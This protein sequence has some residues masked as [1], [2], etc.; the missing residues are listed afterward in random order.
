MKSNEVSQGFILIGY[1][2]FFISRFRKNKKSILI[3]DNISRSCFIV[4][5]YLFGSINSIEH[6]IYGMIRNVVGQLLISRKNIYKIA[7]F[8]VM[9]V[10][11]F[12]MYGMSFSGISTILFLLSGTINLCTAIFAREQGIRLGTVFAAVCNVTAFLIIGSYAS[13]VGETLCGIM[14]LLSFIKEEKKKMRTSSEM[15]RKHKKLYEAFN[16]KDK[17]M[18]IEAEHN[19]DLWPKAFKFGSTGPGRGCQSLEDAKSYFRQCC[20]NDS[21][22]KGD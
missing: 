2:I 22:L 14:G 4:G 18:M 11:L 19:R 3:T 17:P 16:Y 8:I 1:F 7:S 5:Y 20:V 15:K 6:T 9:L 10:V 21:D 12:I 13:I